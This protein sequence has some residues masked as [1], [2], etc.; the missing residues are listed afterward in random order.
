MADPLD[1]AEDNL[2]Q[3]LRQQE[4]AQARVKK[5]ADLAP[6]MDYRRQ[7]ISEALDTQSGPPLAREAAA[8]V[9]DKNTEDMLNYYNFLQFEQD[10]STL[11]ERRAI[12]EAVYTGRVP[13]GYEDSDFL[14]QQ[15]RFGIIGNAL[16]PGVA[17]KAGVFRDITVA[18]NAAASSQVPIHE[19]MHPIIKL[20][21]KEEENAIRALDYFRMKRYGNAEEAQKLLKEAGFDVTQ[22]RDLGKARVLALKGAMSMTDDQFE[23]LSDAERAELQESFD[24]YKEAPGLISSAL[25]ALLE[26]KPQPEFDNILVTPKNAAEMS[27]EDF[28]ALLKAAPAFAYEK[29][30]S[31]SSIDITGPRMVGEGESAVQA[32][33]DGGPVASQDDLFPDTIKKGIATLVEYAPKVAKVAGRGIGDLVRSEPVSPPELATEPPPTDQLDFIAS[34]SPVYSH[35][36]PAIA[37]KVV[38]QLYDPSQTMVNRSDLFIL[39]EKMGETA[40]RISKKALSTLLND[41]RQ[42]IEV[43]N[44]RLEVQGKEAGVTPSPELKENFNQKLVVDR[45]VDFIRNETGVK[46][47]DQLQRMVTETVMTTTSKLDPEGMADGGVVGLKDK[48]VNMTRGPRSNG[49]MQY[50]P[51]ITGATNGY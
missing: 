6:A 24:A 51:F 15:G 10:P 31:D 9:I 26:D 2:Q 27:E 47:P 21:R 5:I 1:L 37:G 35:N 16:N 22:P 25:G 36:I 43:Q 4:L 23:N 48:A 46:D 8:Q 30:F 41:I 14:Y 40:P 38:N 33:E 18:G 28:N 45:L 44:L 17:E 29:I 13:F 3:Y 20:P 39:P 19:G 12:D 42:Q 34:F 11:L 32:Y 49:I 50:V 7:R